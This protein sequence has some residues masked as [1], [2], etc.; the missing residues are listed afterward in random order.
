M[1]TRGAKPIPTALHEM[2]GSKPRKSR[3]NEPRPGGTPAIP[4]HLKDD[5]RR[6]WNE[7]WAALGHTGVLTAADATVLEMLAVEMAR[8]RRACA[9]VA[10]DGDTLTS[11][12]GN[13]Y[14]HPAF[15]IAR[16]SFKSVQSLLGE[17]GLTPAA[18]TRLVV[19]TDQADPFSEFLSGNEESN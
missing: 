6:V 4:K 7:V 18:R 1:A 17:L 5:E 10:V 9:I 11:Q 14:A 3:D 8:Y 2:S 13:K 12:T 16:A 19:P 15:N